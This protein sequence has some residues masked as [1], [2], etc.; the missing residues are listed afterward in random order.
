M[1]PAAAAPVNKDGSSS[2]CVC[3]SADLGRSSMALA[4]RVSTCPSCGAEKA[5]CCGNL[6]RF[7]NLTVA[8]T[9]RI[10]VTSF[11]LGRASLCSVSCVCSAAFSGLSGASAVLELVAVLVAALSMNSFRPFYSTAARAP[12][13][14]ENPELSG[15]AGV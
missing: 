15:W 8:R 7:V 11:G 3:I 1:V 9:V 6:A 12:R 5:C 10:T 14:P 2:K 4:T 13:T